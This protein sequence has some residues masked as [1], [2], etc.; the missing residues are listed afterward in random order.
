[1][2][3]MNIYVTY[4]TD[5]EQFNTRTF[6]AQNDKMA[7]RIINDSMEQDNSFKRNAKKIELWCLGE[8][9]IEA[10]EIKAQKRNLGTCDKLTSTAS[11]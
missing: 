8:Y 10:G 7:K 11:E 5:A 2:A 1:M 3:K 6:H 4:D 9:D